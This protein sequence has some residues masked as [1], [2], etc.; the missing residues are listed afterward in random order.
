L[1]EDQLAP[2]WYDAGTGKS[3]KRKGAGSTS[4]QEKKKKAA[5]TAVAADD[6][7]G[8]NIPQGR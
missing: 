7:A 4:Q 8:M 2:N 5:A 6:T 1:K 3:R